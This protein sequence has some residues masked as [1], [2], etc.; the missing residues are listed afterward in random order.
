MGKILTIVPDL[1]TMGSKLILLIIVAVIVLPLFH[2][3]PK[4]WHLLQI[5]EVSVLQE[6]N[7]RVMA[8]QLII[9]E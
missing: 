6:H 8:H 9:S 4:D 3:L 2:N 7:V 1:Y 5:S